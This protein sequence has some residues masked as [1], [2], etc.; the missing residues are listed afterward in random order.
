MWRV[1]VL[2]RQGIRHS[3]L[4]DGGACAGD[5]ALLAQVLD[6]CA[7]SDWRCRAPSVAP[8]FSARSGAAKEIRMRPTSGTSCPG[9]LD[10]TA[11][12]C[13]LCAIQM[14]YNRSGSKSTRR[15][16]MICRCRGISRC[17]LQ[18]TMGLQPCVPEGLHSPPDYRV[19]GMRSQWACEFPNCRNAAVAE[20]RGS[21][22]YYMCTAHLDGSCGACGLAPMC[23]LCLVYHECSEL[24]PVVRM[25]HLQQGH[26]VR[27]ENVERY[28]PEN[29]WKRASLQT[30]TPFS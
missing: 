19:T 22:A 8:G 13:T 16:S 30:G 9:I 23:V 21:C 18:A 12:W 17:M 14:L 29:Q 24:Q 10:P 1:F 15:S 3:D 26:G 5:V 6:A 7:G 27:E 4:D 11:R 28:K 2:R 20:C 25:R